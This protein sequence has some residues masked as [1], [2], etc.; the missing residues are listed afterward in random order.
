MVAGWLWYLGL[1]LRPL[2]LV[3]LLKPVVSLA[4]DFT[5]SAITFPSLFFNHTYDAD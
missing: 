1:Y 2:P 4:Y 5:M 3:A